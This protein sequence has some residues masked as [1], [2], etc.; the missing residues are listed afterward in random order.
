MGFKDSWAS[1]FGMTPPDYTT[2]IGGQLPA[3]ESLLAHSQVIPSAFKGGGS[4]SISITQ[5][6]TSKLINV[7][8]DAVSKKRHMGGE[9]GTRAHTLSRDGAMKVLAFTTSGLSLWDFGAMGTGTPGDLE[10]TI[11]RNEIA[12]F[13]DTGE[14]AQ[15]GVP[16]ARV[17]FTDGSF[18]DYRLM[19]K[20][21]DDFWSAIT[22][23]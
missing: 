7:A 4:A 3:G 9:E 5:R 14:R 21:G 1:A 22:G 17:T 19:S 8:A 15:G 12:S 6:I 20:P 10:M 23:W 18:F 11:P 13:E 16:V 2:E